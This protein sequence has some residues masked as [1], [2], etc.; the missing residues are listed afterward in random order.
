MKAKVIVEVEKCSKCPYSESWAG[1]QR[2]SIEKRESND[3]VPD[4]CPFVLKEYLTFA[5]ELT[6]DQDWISKMDANTKNIWNLPELAFDRGINYA[7]KTAEIAKAFLDVLKDNT[8]KDFFYDEACHSIE[9]DKHIATITALLC[10]V[11]VKNEPKKTVI[12]RFL[13]KSGLSE[14]DKDIIT[15]VILHYNERDKLFRDFDKMKELAKVHKTK[16]ILD[17]GTA[18]KVALLLASALNIGPDRVT[19]STY[20]VNI[21]TFDNNIRT[22]ALAFKHI[23]NVDFRLTYNENLG[24]SAYRSPK[25]AA[26][27]H[28]TVSDGFDVNAL[29]LWPELLTIPRDIAK[30]FFGFRSFKFFVNNKEINIGRFANNG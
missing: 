13:E 4:W 2:C 21:H 16:P 27:L 23:E 17:T 12:N 18:A 5:W 22:L 9:R 10:E 30:N 26:E 24:R 15:D 3:K 1:K 14:E 25:N 11:N 8:F 29:K 28:Y 20:E 19:T 6:D 7:T